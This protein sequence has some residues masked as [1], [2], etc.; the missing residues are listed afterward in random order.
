MADGADKPECKQSMVPSGQGV[1]VGWPWRPFEGLH[2]AFTT[3]KPFALPKGW[4]NCPICLFFSLTRQ[5]HPG[6]DSHRSGLPCSQAPTLDS[7]PGKVANSTIPR[8]EHGIFDPHQDGAACELCRKASQSEALGSASLRKRLDSE[9]GEIL[10]RF[11]L[12][13]EPA[14]DSWEVEPPGGVAAVSD[15]EEPAGGLLRYV[16][17]NEA[18][19][20]Q[21][22]S[23][24]QPERSKAPPDWIFDDEKMRIFARHLM[25]SAIGDAQ[26]RNMARSFACL[27]MY[28]R[29]GMRV[30]EI[31]AWLDMEEEQAQ[32]FIRRR[33][34][35]AERFFEER[36]KRMRERQ[37]RLDGPVGHGK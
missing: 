36:E 10:K 8:C 4:E 30:P 7:P 20:F 25:S 12:S 5:R 26:R 28:Y 17:Y 14:A 32:N 15:G 16:D 23:P 29:N 1:P 11:G 34:K 18:L 22:H 9:A 3:A 37:A 2:K 6:H 33:T 13:R 31:A 21:V 35:R 27:Y 19:G 24:R